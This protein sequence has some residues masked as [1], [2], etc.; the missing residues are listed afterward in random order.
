MFRGL[1]VA[2]IFADAQDS[3][4]MLKMLHIA[5]LPSISKSKNSNHIEVE[6]KKNFN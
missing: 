4:L 3:E 1:S 2:G 5:I 6:L